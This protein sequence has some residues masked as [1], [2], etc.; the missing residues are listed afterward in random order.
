M[1]LLKKSLLIAFAGLL[2]GCAVNPITGQAELMFFGIDQD[3]EIGRTYSPEIQEQLGGPVDD[4]QLQ[5]YVNRVG[6][7]VAQV[8]HR[9][10]LPYEFTVVDDDSMNAL[11][12]PGGPIFITRGML[13]QLDSESQ[14]AGILAHE[15]AHV[16]ARHGTAQ[17]SRQIGMELVLNAVIGD[18]APQGLMTVAQVGSQI[19][20]L[21]YSRDQ[22][23][24]A[25]IAG[26]DYMVDAGYNP[27]G[28]KHVMQ[29]LERLTAARPPEFL[30]THPSPENRVGYIEERILERYPEYEDIRQGTEQYRLNVLNRLN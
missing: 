21:R 9:P 10:D 29:T 7:S 3:I 26:I 18:E 11:A 17:M 13:E 20:T 24:Q 1:Y 16:V 8:S 25:D 15:V 28:M 30:A 2:V 14:L 6:Q 22:E 4:P 27:Y 12:L 23:R 19:L 5:Q